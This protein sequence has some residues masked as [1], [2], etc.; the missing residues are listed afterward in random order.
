ML[1]VILSSHAFEQR[2][3]ARDPLTANQAFE[4]SNGPD[5]NGRE[6]GKLGRDGAERRAEELGC[7]W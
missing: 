5:V 6:S 7:R 4:E 3:I 1:K 2:S